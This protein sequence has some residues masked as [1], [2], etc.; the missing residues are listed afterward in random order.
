MSSS[1]WTKAISEKKFLPN[2]VHSESESQRG[3]IS[4]LITGLLIK[5]VT[6]N[7]FRV[8]QNY[9]VY[10]SFSFIYKTA[11][12]SSIHAFHLVLMKA[13]HMLCDPQTIT[14]SFTSTDLE[15]AVCT[16]KEMWILGYCYQ[17]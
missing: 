14:W 5:K 2:I 1:S 3:N 12:T 16:L 9:K 15:K 11:W 17:S 13:F 10:N 7:Y 4:T 8:I 6:E